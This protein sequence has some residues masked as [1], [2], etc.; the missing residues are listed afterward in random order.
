MRQLTGTDRG[1]TAGAWP[2]PEDGRRVRA[3][4]T[5]ARDRVGANQRIAIGA[6]ECAGGPIHV[7]FR[8]SVGHQRAIS[9]G[10]F[11]VRDATSQGCRGQIGCGLK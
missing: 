10:G 8:A 9:V 7:A 4:V 3:V 1:H 11:K 5:L 2:I 6:V